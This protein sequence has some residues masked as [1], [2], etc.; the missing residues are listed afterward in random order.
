VVA[1]VVENEVGKKEK[2]VKGGDE[3]N[4]NYPQDTVL[5]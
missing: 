3:S 2:G 1:K 5:E 4:F